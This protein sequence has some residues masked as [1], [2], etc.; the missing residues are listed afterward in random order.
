MTHT[1]GEWKV[2]RY[3]H[4]ITTQINGTQITIAALG[5]C[6]ERVENAKLIAASPDLLEALN[7]VSPLLDGL[8]NRTSTGK[9]R[10]ELCDLNIKIKSAINK[11][12]T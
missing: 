5:E 6:D 2:D 9:K 11:A 3:I 4:K 8:I 10:D 12:T 1:K 7:D